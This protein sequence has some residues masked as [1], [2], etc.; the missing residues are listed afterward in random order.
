MRISTFSRFK[1][2]LLFFIAFVESCRFATPDPPRNALVIAIESSPLQLDPRY[3]TDA[4][5]ARL[6]ALIYNSL[7]RVNEKLELEPELAVSIQQPD[8]Q[9]YAVEL[10]PGV[11]FHDGRVLTAADVKYTYDSILDP[12]FQSPR[13]GALKPLRSVE[14]LG[15]LRLRFRLFAPYAPF[16]EQLTIGIVPAGSARPATANALPAPGSG[17]FIID[18]MAAG[19]IFSFRANRSYW[20]GAPRLDGVSVKVIPDAMVRVLEFKKGTVQFLQ[21]DIEPDVVPWLRHNTAAHIEAHTGTTFQ[22]IGMNLENPILKNRQVRQ[23]IAQAI[24]RD[25]MIRHLLKGGATPATGLLSPINWAYEGDVARWPYNPEEAKRLLDRA[26]Y[27]DPDGDG[28]LPR[29]TL[30]F[31]TTNVDLRIRMAEAIQAQL[32]RVGIG[33]DIRAYEWGTFYSDIKKGNFHLYSLAWVG[34]LDPDIYYQIFHSSSV[35]PDG[36]N[37]GRYSNPELDRLLQEGRTVSHRGERKAIYRKV[38]QTVAEDLP[39]IPLWWWKNVVVTAPSLRGF[40]PYPDGDFV[41]LRNAYFEF[42]ENRT[43]T[44]PTVRNARLPRR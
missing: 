3:A 40:V 23:A 38:Q 34:V 25:G 43:E 8:Q 35:P 11:R 31:K 27:P 21:N 2:L 22:Y 24:D 14:Q 41:S 20:Q 9:T 33:L 12:S 17:P 36:D 5:S 4:N 32:K 28:P 39:Y 30:S 29:F 6:D 16:L 18:S 15:D 26:G 7:L 37:R 10:R 44:Q 13:R 42:A 1:L 19:E